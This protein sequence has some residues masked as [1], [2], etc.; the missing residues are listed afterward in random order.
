MQDEKGVGACAATRLCTT[1]SAAAARLCAVLALCAG[2]AAAETLPPLTTGMVKDTD[3]R[4]AQTSSSDPGGFTAIDGKVYFAATTAEFGRELYTTDG[5]AAGLRLF[6]DLAP[7]AASSYPNPLSTL[8]NKLI[9]EASISPVGTQLWAVDTAGATMRLT[10]LAGFP[11]TGEPV[12]PGF[13]V[14]ANLGSRLLVVEKRGPDGDVLWATDGTAAGTVKL[15]ASADFP[16]ASY[17]GT[18]CRLGSGVVFVGRLPGQGPRA[19]IYT[20]GTVGGSR[21]LANLGEYEAFRALQSYPVADSQCYF[22]VSGN[23]WQLWSTDA[24][25]AGT[26]QAASGIGQPLGFMMHAGYQYIADGT[27]VRYRLM[28]RAPTATATLTTL[29]DVTYPTTYFDP[30]QSLAM[31]SNGGKLIYLA[32]YAN[33][34]VTEYGLYLGDGTPAGTR[35]LASFPRY[36]YPDQF[37]DVAGG[38]MYRIDNPSSITNGLIYSPSGVMAALPSGDRIGL[39]DSVRVAGVRIGAGMTSGGREVVV[40]DGTDAGTRLLHDVWATTRGLVYDDGH[41]P[42]AQVALGDALYVNTLRSDESWAVPGVTRIDGTPAGTRTLPPATYD[43]QRVNALAAAWGGLVFSTGYSNSGRAYRADPGLAAAT[44]LTPLTNSPLYPLVP[45]G[46]YVFSQCRSAEGFNTLCRIEANGVITLVQPFSFE[47]E[48]ETVMGRVGDGMILRQGWNGEVLRTD[49]T[50]AGT[51][52][53]APAGSALF[54]YGGDNPPSALMNGK[55]YFVTC[56]TTVSCELQSTDGTVAG[57]SVVASLPYVKM[58]WMTALGDRLVFAMEMSGTHLWRSDGTAAGTVD[59]LT[60]PAGASGP[61]AVAGGRIHIPLSCEACAER[62]L[63]TDG[64]LEGTRALPTPPTLA[65]LAGYGGT[66]FA[67]GRSVVVFSCRSQ[68]TGAELCAASA[69]GSDIRFLADIWPGA[70]DSM[71][72]WLGATR[73]AAYFAA[74]DGTHG[75]EIWQVK[76]A[77]EAIFASGFDRSD[78]GQ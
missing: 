73:Q 51:Y 6:K 42:P 61:Y 47:S 17:D 53:I 15:T 4:Q 66:L 52:P 16:V 12:Y 76:V 69:D 46:D 63:V 75:R 71:P 70:K 18:P 67:L 22:L 24:T 49:G 25:A 11:V 37:Y 45:M 65:P 29:A 59:V 30:S 21:Q 44:A 74:D 56:S 72:R 5:S 68:A 36:W 78:A 20:D 48:P 50:P 8:G 2:V 3:T 13:S 10:A 62:Y 60:L 40:S 41:L 43:G 23:G 19:L 58:N 39:G 26:R 9:V 38:V 31:T 57:T 1:T 34:Q 32:P 7:G 33:G 64:T 14:V 35:R 55:L 54:P 28:R 77:D 27:T